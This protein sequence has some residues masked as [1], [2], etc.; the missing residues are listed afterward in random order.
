MVSFF[1]SFEIIMTPILI[2]VNSYE[3]LR[4]GPAA[5]LISSIFRLFSISNLTVFVSE[6]REN[7]LM[8][9][10]CSASCL[11]NYC[12]VFNLLMHLIY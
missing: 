10:E 8:K 3:L 12:L 5:F 4:V 6:M 9:R 11:R 1:Y 7:I 2:L